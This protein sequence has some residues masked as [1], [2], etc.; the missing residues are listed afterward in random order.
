MWAREAHPKLFVSMKVV[1]DD[2]T[3]KE[4]QESESCWYWEQDRILDLGT[5]TLIIFKTTGSNIEL[6]VTPRDW[7][8]A[9]TWNC[10]LVSVVINVL[11]KPANSQCEPHV[12]TASS[13]P[14]DKDTGT[15]QCIWSPTLVCSWLCAERFY[16]FTQED[17]GH[18]IFS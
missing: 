11:S 9:P 7:V 13:P 3:Q 2:M 4:T 15:L 5:Q 8:C 14:W 10:H 12:S 16:F 17:G 6:S 18:Y 1:S